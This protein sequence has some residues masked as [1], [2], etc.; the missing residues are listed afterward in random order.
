MQPHELEIRV[1]DSELDAAAIIKN[2]EEETKSEF[3]DSDILSC[4]EDD[5]VVQ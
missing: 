5:D 3:A 1:S 2:V 4:E